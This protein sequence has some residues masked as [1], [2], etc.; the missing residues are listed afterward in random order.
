MLCYGDWG[1]IPMDHARR[2]SWTSP[3]SRQEG[4][5]LEW[6]GSGRAELACFVITH[7]AQVRLLNVY[8]ALD[9]KQSKLWYKG[10]IPQR[11]R[12]PQRK[13]Q[14]VIWFRFPVYR[15]SNLDFC[16]GFSSNKIRSIVTKLCWNEWK[17]IKCEVYYRLYILLLVQIVYVLNIEVLKLY[18]FAECT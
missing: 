13:E 3:A 1:S 8:L 5:I 14:K 2:N 11:K 9:Q 18:W 4:Y 16:W 7:Q 6:V 12:L 15:D 10:V 17:V